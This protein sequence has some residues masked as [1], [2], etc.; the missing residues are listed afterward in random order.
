MVVRG[1]KS[2]SMIQKQQHSIQKLTLV[3]IKESKKLSSGLGAI[4]TNKKKVELSLFRYV[5]FALCLYVSISMSKIIV[6]IRDIIVGRQPHR[7]LFESS[8]CHQGC[9]LIA[10]KSQK[11]E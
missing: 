9:L 3:C 7:R 10:I 6:L 5:N 2:V 11:W 1:V 4:A 8:M